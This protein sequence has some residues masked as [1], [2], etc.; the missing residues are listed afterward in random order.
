M[1]KINYSTKTFESKYTYKGNDPGI[2]WTK[3]GTTFSA[4]V[5]EKC[6]K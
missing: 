4:M 5:L 1:G 3:E 6:T 2:L